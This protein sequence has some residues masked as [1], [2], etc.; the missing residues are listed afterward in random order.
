MAK[1]LTMIKSFSQITTTELNVKNSVKLK[2][3]NGLLSFGESSLF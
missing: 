2:E 1:Q 3:E